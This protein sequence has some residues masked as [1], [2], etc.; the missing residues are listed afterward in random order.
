VSA[1]PHCENGLPC[2]IPS[3]EPQAEV[4][5][6][7]QSPT[8]RWHLLGRTFREVKSLGKSAL[9][10]HLGDQ[11]PER[12]ELGAG[13]VF[14]SFERSVSAGYVLDQHGC[15]R[16]EQQSQWRV[17]GQHPHAPESV[18]NATFITARRGRLHKYLNNE[19]APSTSAA[20]TTSAAANRPGA[21]RTSQP[22]HWRR[23]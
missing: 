20:R 18:A 16:F 9:L 5:T 3:T 23:N 4:Q 7:L 22:C 15:L 13:P 17:R 19:I 14:H 21:A 8:R 12:R 6:L 2:P 1:T 10:P 11:A